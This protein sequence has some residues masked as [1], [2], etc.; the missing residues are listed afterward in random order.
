MGRVSCNRTKKKKEAKRTRTM[1]EWSK[2]NVNKEKGWSED[3]WLISFTIQRPF[4]ASLAIEFRS[5]FPQGWQNLNISVQQVT[6]YNCTLSTISIIYF[7]WH[8]SH[9]QHALC[10]TLYAIFAP[11]LV[12]RQGCIG[13]MADGERERERGW[14]GGGG[15]GGRE[16][17]K[18]TFKYKILSL[19]KSDKVTL[20]VR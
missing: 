5:Q 17:N 10:K 20:T 13:Q 18:S 6:F 7:L 1:D 2:N 14:R 3:M 12:L 15:G 16:Q 19:H 8:I 11:V 4:E 9:F